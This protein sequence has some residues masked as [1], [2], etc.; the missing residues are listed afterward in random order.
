VDTKR[1]LILSVTVN[2][3]P[4]ERLV[5]ARKTL[6]DFLREDAGCTSVH[7]GCEHGVCG[8][9][10][11]LVDGLAVRSCLRLA[12]QAE[13]KQ[14][15]TLDGIMK[16]DLGREI[17]NAF[18]ENFG[19]QCGFCTAGFA[20]SLYQLLHDARGPV[21][22][23]DLRETLGGHICRCTGYTSILN[24]ARQANEHAGAAAVGD[25]D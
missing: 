3:T 4:V 5:E 6:A 21:S 13:G 22:E 2:G 25:K 18:L 10:T 17:A 1:K 9:C 19:M 15:T 23:E 12:A 7:L 11:V 24:A 16:T 20:V 8:A 14:I